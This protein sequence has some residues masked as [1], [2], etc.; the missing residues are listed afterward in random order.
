MAQ[1]WPIPVEAPTSQTRLPA[2]SV[3]GVFKGAPHA[4]L[5]GAFTGCKTPS[6]AAGE[7]CESIQIPCSTF[8]E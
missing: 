4:R 5:L 3:I 6:G 8:T 2:Q 1:A 7:K